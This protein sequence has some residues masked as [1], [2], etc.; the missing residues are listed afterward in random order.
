MNGSQQ[1]RISLRQL[2]QFANQVYSHMQE[3][4]MMDGRHVVITPS[5]P[6]GLY[7]D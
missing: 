7:Y 5:L 6:I 2:R 3:L 4:G 1:P